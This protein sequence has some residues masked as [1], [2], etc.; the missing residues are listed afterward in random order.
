[1]GCISNCRIVALNVGG[2]DTAHGAR[3]PSALY[4]RVWIA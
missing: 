4:I 1:M 3:E 2:G